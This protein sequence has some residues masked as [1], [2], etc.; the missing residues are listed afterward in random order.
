MLCNK[1]DSIVPFSFDMVFHHTL[2]FKQSL[3]YHRMLQH[4]QL[5]KSL[6]SVVCIPVENTFPSSYL[7]TVAGVKNWILSGDG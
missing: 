1:Y 6:P 4:A 5:I 2:H 3:D 7:A